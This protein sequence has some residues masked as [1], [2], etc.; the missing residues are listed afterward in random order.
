MPSFQ[1]IYDSAPLPREERVM[2]F[3]PVSK[4][5]ILHCSYDWWYPKFT[6]HTPRTKIIPLPQEVLDYL[7]EDGIVLADSG[8][9]EDDEDD[10]KD[11]IEWTT[12]SANR[13]SSPPP[14]IQSQMP[15]YA[16]ADGDQEDSDDSEGLNLTPPNRRFPEF[17]QQL[18]DAIAELGGAVAPKLNWS[19]PKDAAFMAG[20]NSLKCIN[21]N[22]IYILLKSS[23]FAAHDLA[24]A[25]DGCE[26][27]ISPEARPATQNTTNLPFAPVLVL[28]TW[29]NIQPSLEFRCFVK[30]NAL[31]GLTQR[32]RNQYDWLPALRGDVVGKANDFF[33]KVLRCRFPDPSYAF[34]VEILEDHGT[35]SKLGTV[36]LIDINPWA[37]RTD[38]LLFDWEELVTMQ[39]PNMMLGT[40][41]PSS[42][43]E[44][45]V[46]DESETGE[47]DDD[48]D[49]E[50]LPE[51]R[52]VE[53]ESHANLMSTEYSAHKLPREVV[54]A[55]ETEGGMAEFL[56]TWQ[57]MQDTRGQMDDQ[58]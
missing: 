45:E 20:D 30:D 1:D 49:A 35:T 36:R 48:E 12:P 6:S 22:D 44:S 42:G 15:E 39:V 19:A 17:H 16:R 32:D 57:R 34:D 43:T 31:V 4:N 3:P 41:E 18:K 5:H 13:A 37:P 7:E 38:T 33:E 27:G 40:A 25:F 54:E 2:Q 23:S 56:T 46:M 24:H 14:E 11:E 28:R 9:D 51:L 53:K 21:P 52:L 47:E 26:G 55:A 8:N 10:D 50:F 58:L 29:C